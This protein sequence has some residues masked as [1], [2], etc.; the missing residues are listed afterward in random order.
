M[1]NNQSNIKIQSI[2]EHV[3]LKD[4]LLVEKNIFPNLERYLKVILILV[5]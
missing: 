5:P 3:G 4:T 2:K 1:M